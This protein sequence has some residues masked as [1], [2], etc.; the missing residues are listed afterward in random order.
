VLVPP[1]KAANAIHAI[2]RTSSP[3][4]T[5]ITPN[6]WDP[7]HIDFFFGPNVLGRINRKKK[8]EK[9]GVGMPKRIT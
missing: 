6:L 2:E 8:V 5:D 3:Y 7:R 4:R 9:L 1:K